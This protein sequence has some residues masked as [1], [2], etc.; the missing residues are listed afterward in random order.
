MEERFWGW[1]HGDTENTTVCH[2]RY[3][4][5]ILPV[6]VVKDQLLIDFVGELDGM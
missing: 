1:E 5:N 4:A 6:D 2:I 3:P